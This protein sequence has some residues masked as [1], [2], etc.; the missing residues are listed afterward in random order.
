MTRQKDLKKL[1]RA[2]MQK[3]GESY[4][5]ARAVLAGRKRNPA[6][7]RTYTAARE[8]WPKLAGMSDD[9]VK[10]ATGCTWAKWVEALD[11]LRAHEMSHAE[12]AR[13]IK[14]KW[15]KISGW[16]SQMVTVG[17]ERIRGLR[18][19]GQRRGGGYEASKS[20]T[21]N[22]GVSDLYALFAPNRIK[23][24][25]PD[26]VGKHRGGTADKTINLDWND[27]T[28]AQFWFT[29][30]G[31]A[32][33]SVAVQHTKLTARSDIEARKRFWTERFAKLKDMLT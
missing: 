4:T 15:P 24:W 31:A 5:S 32:K 20:R 8:N 33:C 14:R 10:A 30:K 19:V 18:E 2:R 12:I 11:Y 26:G 9:K 3:T 7:A 17:Y 1:V 28:K 23:S 29:R 6:T 27:G 25:L 22:V 16:W 13:L 21:F